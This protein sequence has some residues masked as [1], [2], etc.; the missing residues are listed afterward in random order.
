M[1]KSYLKIAL[2]SLKRHKVFSIINVLGLSVG[3]ACCM[4]IGLYIS[5]ETSY[6]KF[7]TNSDNIYRFTREFISPDGSTS[8]HLSRVAPPFGPLAKEDFSGEIEKIGRMMSVSGPVKYNNRLYDEDNFY[9][10]DPEIA[11]ILT[12]DVIEGNIVQAL[13][14]P[15]SVVISDEMAYKYFGDE[16]PIGKSINFLSQA[17]LIV[18]G[19][20]KKLPENSSFQVDFLAEMTPLEAFYGGREAMMQNWGSNNFATFF[21]LKPEGRIS[22]IERR[23][24]DFLNKHI[25][26]EA[27][28]WTALHVQKL[29][30]IHLHSNLDDEQGQNSDITYV[31][32]FASIAFLI[33]AIA[34]INY[35]NLA[36]ARSATRAKEVGMR[37]VFGAGKGKLINQFLVESIVLVFFALFLAVGVT[38]LILP[39]FRAFTGLQLEF[40]LFTN[41]PLV[42]VILTSAVVVGVLSGSYPAFYLSS[43]QPLKV[44]KGKLT[45]GAKSGNLRRFLVVVQFTI[46]VI[47]IVSTIVVFKQLDFIQN[48]KLGYDREQMMI[49]GVSQ[50]VADQYEAFKNELLTIQ[51]VK[52]VGGSSRVPSGQLLDSQG[53]QAEVNGEMLPTP[54]VIKSLSVDPDFIPTYQMEMASGRNFSDNFANDSTSFVLNEK[55]VEVIGWGSAEDAIGQNMIY[56]GVRGKVIGVVKDFHFESLQSEISPII[57][58]NRPNQMRNLSIKIEGTNIRSAIQQ[59]EELYANFSPNAPLN[60]N[61]LD[62]RFENLYT[63]ETQRSQL[64]TLFSGLAIFLACLGLFGLASFTVSQRSKE[65]SIRKVLGASVQQIVG[66]LSKEFVILIAVAMLLAFPVAWY[67]MNDW[68]AGYAYRTTLGV[69]P[70]LLAALIAGAIAFVTISF[71]TFKAAVS[72]PSER[73]RDE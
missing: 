34:C 9:F 15:G 43:F 32:I 4:L 5:E 22:E 71:Q 26:E 53:A 10:A 25:D 14:Q 39:Y 21:T 64:F 24:G 20:F 48:K 16:D 8:L 66:I 17:D 56:A 55:S 44:L 3:L 58:V 63:T 73:L 45:G 72:N 40:D 68:L 49:M 50:Q 35:M 6:D 70:F 41:L 67:F 12:F 51:G 18:K 65:I 36:T 30:D 19:V 31:Y 52:M 27:T 38:S 37:K 59:V 2:R 13:T 69:S 61:F 57:M 7:H 28:T 29:T 47:L 60:Y 1:L 42:A 54:V 46:S 11:A 23:M 62:D 33:L